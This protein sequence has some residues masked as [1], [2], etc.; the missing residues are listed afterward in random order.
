MGDRGHPFMVPRK[1]SILGV[2]RL[3]IVSTVVVSDCMRL[4]KLQKQGP[5]CFCLMVAERK[6]QET[7]SNAFSTTRLKRI[8]LCKCWFW[9]SNVAAIEVLMFWTE[10]LDFT[11][12][13]GSGMNNGR[14]K[15]L[16]TGSEYFC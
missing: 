8:I 2:L 13:L 12:P 5:N 9:A 4:I 14:E 1:I 15:G 16:D 10:C 3:L 7:L 11:N 6:G